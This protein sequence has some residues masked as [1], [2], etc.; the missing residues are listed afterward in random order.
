M[1]AFAAGP[2][3]I[4]CCSV[5][6]FFWGVPCMY[7]FPLWLAWQR[8]H[9]QT[10]AIGARKVLLGWTLLGWTLGVVRALTESDRAKG[11]RPEPTRLRATTASSAACAW[12]ENTLQASPPQAQ[13]KDTTSKG[14]IDLVSGV[15]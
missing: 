7:L 4:Y 8:H 15:S 5:L 11:R 10:L 1:G 6:N 14:S 13:R 2:L 3:F 12:S 9:R